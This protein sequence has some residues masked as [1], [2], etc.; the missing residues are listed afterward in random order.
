MSPVSG[1]AF[2]FDEL[3][4]DATRHRLFAVHRQAGLVV[5]TAPDAKG[6]KLAPPN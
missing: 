6:G 4:W 3:A 1:R 5:V 2:P